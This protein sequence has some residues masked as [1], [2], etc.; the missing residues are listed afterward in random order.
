MTV[1]I[2]VSED[3]YE[4]IEA[5]GMSSAELARKLGVSENTVRSAVAHAERKGGNS[6]YKKVVIDEE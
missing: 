6:M 4:L 5:M 3:K 1:W 2:K